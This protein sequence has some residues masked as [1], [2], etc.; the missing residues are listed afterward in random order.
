[1]RMLAY[2]LAIVCVILAVMYYTMQA[3]QLPTFMPGYIA[4]S[5]HIHHTHALAAAAAAVI[6]F[7]L[8]WFF[9]RSRRAA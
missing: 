4:G 6:L 3:G 8:G 2:V 5:T 7:V 1:M 9:G